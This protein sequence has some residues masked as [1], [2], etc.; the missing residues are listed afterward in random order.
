MRF[1]LVIGLIVSIAQQVTGIN[2]VFFYA[3]S[4]FEQSGVGTN[5]AF[6]QAI[7]VGLI[8]VLFTVVA[9]YFIDK[10]GRKPLLVVG[11]SGVAISMACIS[12]GFNQATYK[13]ENSDIIEIVEQ[14]PELSDIATIQ[15]IEYDSDV[16]FKNAVIGAVGK[17]EFNDAQGLILS[18][19]G[20]LNAAII[21]A[22]ILG[23]V[24]S[25]AVSLG[26]VMWVMFSEIFPNHIRGVAISFVGV[27][28]SMV[29]FTVTLVF[30]W[31]LANWGAATVFFIYGAFAA[32][33][34]I[35]VT[36]LFPETKGK[37]LEALEAELTA[38]SQGSQRA[39]SATV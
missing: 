36:K 17:S 23:F 34:L 27:I 14:H 18:L 32:I 12:Y 21:L 37:S 35:L 9:M 30:P 13:L 16:A 10:W 24:A 25:F 28:N 39:S 19:A 6:A 22:G 15:D 5:A 4:I 33:G 1:A 7:L 29:S 2:T 3:P 31:E 8:N 26:P 38:K 20:N 11:L